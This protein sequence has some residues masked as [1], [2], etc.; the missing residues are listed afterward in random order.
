MRRAVY[1]P[2]SC[3]KPTSEIFETDSVNLYTYHGSLTTPPCTEE[4]IWI[5]MKDASSASVEQIELLQRLMPKNNYRETQPI[6][7]RKIYH[8]IITD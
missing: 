2:S 3:Q 1:L 7:D 5:V 4:V 6:N 8:E